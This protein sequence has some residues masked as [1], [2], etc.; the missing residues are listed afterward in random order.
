MKHKF[1]LIVIL[2]LLSG[3]G[4][5]QTETF[6]VAMDN[7]MHEVSGE[8]KNYKVLVYTNAKLED[9]PSPSTKSI[10]GNINGESTT[11]LLTINANYSD[12]DSFKV[13]VYEDGTLVGE[14]NESVLSGDTLKF[15]NINI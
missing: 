10:Y 13:K 12:G 8:F 2:A 4:S 6:H 11:S 15:S 14:S 7:S 1:K 9:S 3:C 5:S